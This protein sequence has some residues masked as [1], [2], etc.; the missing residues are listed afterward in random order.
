MN[1]RTNDP[2]NDDRVVLGDLEAPTSPPTLRLVHDG[3]SVPAVDRVRPLPPPPARRYSS[4]QWLS[5][6][7]TLT[8]IA[9]LSVAIVLFEPWPLLAGLSLAVVVVCGMLLISAEAITRRVTYGDGDR[10]PPVRISDLEDGDTA[11][12]V[13]DV[14]P[15]GI[16]VRPLDVN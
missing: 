1:Q 14:I 7:V 2:D 8:A 9:V 15:A 3:D 16:Y 13:G 6:A 4:I 12:P 5:F 11:A 10:P